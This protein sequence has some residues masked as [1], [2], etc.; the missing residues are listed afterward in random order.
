MAL[1]PAR[2]A[3]RALPAL[4]AVLVAALLAGCAG[5]SPSG[6][7]SP[8]AS[9]SSP[10]AT[11]PGAASPTGTALPST[12]G[13]ASTSPV[14]A[15]SEVTQ[16]TLTVSGSK[17]TGDTPLVQ[18][19]TGQAVRLVVTSDVADEVH[20]H[21]ADVSQDVEAG[22]TA[23]LEFTQRSPGRFEVELESARRVLTRLQVR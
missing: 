22:G 4:P 15:Q 5:T 19:R 2:R 21:G 14:P 9:S 16:L 7:A 8:S 1:L 17:V 6:T 20:V 13:K 10:A 23:V 3:S 11:S 18:L 12:P